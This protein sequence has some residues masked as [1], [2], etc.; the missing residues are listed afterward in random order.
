MTL[1]EQ[2]IQEIETM[3]DE[4]LAEIL[5]FAGFIKYKRTQQNLVPQLQTALPYRQ[6]S[7]RSILKCAG[8][9]QGDDFEEC[10]EMV[11]TSRGK[12]K[13]DKHINPFE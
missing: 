5:D 3:P 7:G 2:L 10:L 6:A 13:F 9:W 4:I 11:Y 8:T 12:A 1:K